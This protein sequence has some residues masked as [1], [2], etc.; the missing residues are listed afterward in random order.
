MASDLRK[1]FEPESV[2]VVGASGTPGKAGHAVMS[3]LVAGGYGGTIYPVN[4]TSTEVLGF[5]AYRSVNDLP[6]VPDVAIIIVPASATVKTLT[7]CAEKGIKA[8]AIVSAG[9]TEVD[10]H[11]AELQDAVVE[12][13]H[14]SG[15][16]VIGP[17]TSG[18]IS[19]PARFNAAFYPLGKIPQG[20]VA[21]VAQTG[22]FGGATMSW[23][24]SAENFGVSRV[25]SLGNKCDVD[26]A[27][28]LEYLGD[29]PETR[30]I[31][32]YLEGFKD[33][34]RFIEAARRVSKMKPIIALKGGMTSTGARAAV[35]HTTSLGMNNPAMIDGI[36]RQAGVAKIR[37]YTEF[38]DTA[39]ALAFQPLPSGRRVGIV[40]PSGAPR[41]PGC[42]HLPRAGSGTC[43]AF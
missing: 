9:F 36:F 22:N 35:S 20:T 42:G 24:L 10:E 1:F 32:I 3:N 41:S 23:I 34:R 11:G 18:L 21:Y 13:A 39:K 7:E 26:D 28:A 31:C 19:T 30:V 37:R 29:D 15:M 27:D 2:A 38:M 16:R 17:N 14:K 8:A 40:V 43:Y 6:E 33:G 4:Q 12:I 5:K 25:I